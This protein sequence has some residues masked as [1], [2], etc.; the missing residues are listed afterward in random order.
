MK[1][2]CA[3]L[4]FFL[5]S[6]LGIYAQFVPSLANCEG[7]VR[8]IHD[9]ETDVTRLVSQKE[10]RINDLGSGDLYQIAIMR[11]HEDFSLIIRSVKQRCFDRKTKVTFIFRDGKKIA[12]KSAHKENCEG[13]VLV[14]MGGI[15]GNESRIQEFLNQYL[16]GIMFENV[17]G[18]IVRLKIETPNN[19]H[20]KEVF[21]CMATGYEK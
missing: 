11:V 5:F 2:N 17:E 12:F 3:F 8:E 13:L 21:E 6:G 15:Y 14:S 10:I 16:V 4:F 19:D 7:I 18:D 20:I 1:L 9:I